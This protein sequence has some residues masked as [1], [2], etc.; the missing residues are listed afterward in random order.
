MKFYTLIDNWV[1]SVIALMVK[2]DVPVLFHRKNCSNGKSGRNLTAGTFYPGF[3]SDWMY[4][5]ITTTTNGFFASVETHINGSFMCASTKRT[6]EPLA[7]R[8]A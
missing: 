6:Y 5:W 3:A 4:Q 8:Y 7:H 2:Q 1:Y